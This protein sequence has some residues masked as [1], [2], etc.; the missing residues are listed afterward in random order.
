[1]CH[2]LLPHSLKFALK[3]HYFNVLHP[4]PITGFYQMISEIV[5]ECTKSEIPIWTPSQFPRGYSFQEEGMTIT[6]LEID[7]LH[8]PKFSCSQSN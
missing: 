3:S 2:S 1:M 5:F 4:L 7:C 8:M 6:L